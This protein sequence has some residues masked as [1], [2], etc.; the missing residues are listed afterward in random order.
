MSGSLGFHP[1]EDR[2]GVGQVAVADAEHG[3]LEAGAVLDEL[4]RQLEVGTAYRRRRQVDEFVGDAALMQGELHACRERADPVSVERDV[5]LS[6]EELR[7]CEQRLAAGAGQHIVDA[8]AVVRRRGRR[9]PL[10]A[11]GGTCPDT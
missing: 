8:G 7:S 2:D 9:M 5:G 4:R 11:T 3:D 6:C 1:L 10:G